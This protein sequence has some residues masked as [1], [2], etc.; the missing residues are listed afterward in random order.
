MFHLQKLITMLK[1]LFILIPALLL[2]AAASAQIVYSTDWKSE[3][4]V[5]VYVTE[6][7]GEA[8]LIVY[9]TEWKS[10]AKDNEG[11]WYFTQW[12]CEAKKAIYFTSW[13]S[14]ADIIV[15]FTE[16]KG[17][18]GWKKKSKKHIMY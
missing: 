10:E 6:Y 4:K 12:K 7:K 1:R 3:A 13:K 8:D 15:Y 2:C 17:E 11:I 18:A 14:E 5:K 9:K 16:Y